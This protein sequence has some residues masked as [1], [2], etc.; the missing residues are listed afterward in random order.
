MYRTDKSR[1]QDSPS[2]VHID[3][4]WYHN[5]WKSGTIA[6]KYKGPKLVNISKK[7]T[8]LCH[9]NAPDVSLYKDP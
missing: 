2:E 9:C 7:Q 4:I 5:L 1:K 6:E 3:K 8:F